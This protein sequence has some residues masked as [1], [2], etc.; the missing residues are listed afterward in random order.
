LKRLYRISFSLLISNILPEHALGL[1]LFFILLVAWLVFIVDKILHRPAPD[2]WES[3]LQ[4]LTHWHPTT[5]ASAQRLGAVDV[6]ENP[7]HFLIV[8][9]TPGPLLLDFKMPFQ[10]IIYFFCPRGK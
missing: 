9:D 6:V 1:S 10:I 2:I 8:A 4:P 3:M 5:V 7:D